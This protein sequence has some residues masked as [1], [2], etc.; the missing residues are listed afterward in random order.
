MNAYM[1]IKRKAV[2]ASAFC[3][4]PQRFDRKGRAHLSVSKTERHPL[5]YSDAQLVPCPVV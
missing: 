3:D 1:L 5:S 2:R 4:V